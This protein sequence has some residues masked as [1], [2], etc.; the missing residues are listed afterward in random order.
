MSNRIDGTDHPDYLVGTNGKD[1]IR[2]KD[3]ND[4]IEA[5]GGDDRIRG[6]DGD[7]LIYAGSGNDRVRGDDGNDTVFG[8]SGDD[9]IRGR[10][11]ND[12]LDGGAGDDVL[13]GGR[14]NDVL[15]GGGGADQFVITSP[16]H[17]VDTITDFQFSQGDKVV[18]DSSGFG[19]VTLSD[20][21][22]TFGFATGT[23]ELFFTPASGGSTLIAELTGLS[24]SS[25][26]IPSLDIDLV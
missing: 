9:R 3:G 18:I 13:N 2:G 4:T 16:S 6:G 19:G 8:G 12:Y 15:T 25:D 5:L 11:G 24:F 17:A 22:S 10:D 21:T 26:F 14:G 7:D 23:A 20:F 1:R